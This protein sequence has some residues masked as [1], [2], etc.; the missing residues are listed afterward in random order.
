MLQSVFQLHLSDPIFVHLAAIGKFD[1]NHPSLAYATTGG[2]VC[3]HSPHASGDQAQVQYLNINKEITAL[4]T[5]QLNPDSSRAI[6]LVGTNTSLQAYDVYTNQDLFFKDISDGVCALAVIQL[7]WVGTPSVVVGG[8]CCILGIDSQGT[9]QFWTVAGDRVTALAVSNVCGKGRSELVAGSDNFCIQALYNESVAE[10]ITEADKVVGLASLDGTKFGYALAN[11][12]VGVYDKG[13]R[14]WRIKSKHA[15]TALCSHDLDGDG[16]LELISGWSNGKIEVRKAESGQVI[17][18]DSMSA[19]VAAI[20]KG[21][22]RGDGADQVVVCAVNGEVRGY[23]PLDPSVA[24]T[25]QLVAASQALKLQELALRKQE[26]LFELQG[27]GV[28][29]V[30]GVSG[31]AHTSYIIPPDTSVQ[32]V[33]MADSI[34]R[35]CS[36]AVSTDS[37]TVIRGVMLFAE[38]VFEGESVFHY[39]QTPSANVEVP[40][41]LKRDAAVT[42]MIKVMVCKQGG[43]LCHVF[44]SE[45][46]LP[47]FCMYAPA[48]LEA[49]P[50]SESTVIF[51]ISER[52][53]RVAMWVEHSF[54]TDNGVQHGPEGVEAHF[55]SLRDGRAL[56][57][58]MR[59][60][61]VV[62]R[63]D[64]LEL[65][66]VVVQDAA[67]YLGLADL[68]STAHFPTHTQQFQAVMA[69]VIVCNT[70]RMKM[71]A[72]A[73]DSSM[74][75]KILVVKAEDARLLGEFGVMKKMYT[76]LQ[77]LNREL[78]MEH[79]KRTTNREE[80]LEALKLVNNM[81]QHAA[82]L[83]VGAAKARVVTACRGAIKANN[84]NALLKIIQDG[85]T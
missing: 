2:K 53:A 28:N 31:E 56:T 57:I 82:K 84:T 27:Y 45:L 34:Q 47:K 70:N 48:D 3:I 37:D 83:R 24:P 33:V 72:E 10:E 68:E 78:V 1:G 16:E 30:A 26:L 14:T 36:L 59:G 44:E 41:A 8:V 19:S 79:E 60:T 7:G 85:R 62:V 38:Q 69:K 20:V 32:T 25:P 54:G 43:A 35:S 23:L 61:K 21:D 11:G 58:S 52:P 71:M 65:A 9:E 77:H 80:L 46:R 39:Q 50:M 67:A 13:N 5:G 63:T 66:G 40:L 55:M 75:I 4:T 51:N 17:F 74:A 29:R 76:Q 12:T 64:D 81:I 42:V 73:A 6:L 22:Y 15:V 18:K 49:L